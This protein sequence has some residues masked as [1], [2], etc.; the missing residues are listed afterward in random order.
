[1]IPKT[2]HYCWFGRGKKSKL[3]KKCIKSWQEYLPDYELKEWNENNFRIEEW[4]FAKEAYDNRK[5]AFVADVVRMYALYHEGGIYMDTDVEALKSFDGFLNCKAFCGFEDD[6]YIAT[7][8]IGSEKGGKWSKEQLDYY[9]GKHFIKNDGSFDTTPNVTHITANMISKGLMQD[10]SYQD[11]PNFMTVYPRDYFSPK[12]YNNNDTYFSDNTISVHHFAG[13]W[14]SS[15]DKRKIKRSKRRAKRK[16][17][18]QA[19]Q[20]FW[21][22]I[23]NM[24]HSK[25]QE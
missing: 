19:R 11:F 14:L 16:Q 20:E 12:S 5:F 17:R 23:K 13:S 15:K 18:K 4:S 8:V 6:T 10:N 24:F 1:M 7:C 9:N 3:V 21:N 25:T 22:R 2:I